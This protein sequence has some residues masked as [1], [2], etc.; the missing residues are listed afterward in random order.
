[1]LPDILTSVPAGRAASDRCPCASDSDVCVNVDRREE[2]LRVGF[3]EEGRPMDEPSWLL[4][5]GA[6][7]QILIQGP[8]Q[9]LADQVRL[10][11]D[12]LHARTVIT[13]DR[14]P[15]VLLPTSLY[16][17]YLYLSAL[18]NYVVMISFTLAT[19]NL[20]PFPFLDGGLCFSS[21]LEWAFPDKADPTGDGSQ[22]LLST[23]GDLDEEVEDGLGGDRPT[24][25]WRNRVEIGV[26]WGTG[27]LGVWV[28]GG[29]VLRLALNGYG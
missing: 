29:I 2:V 25:R 22:S 24:A 4:W 23:S 9:D 1:M 28:L 3:V 10:P 14:R 7:Q 26:A 17:A 11:T 8:P 15:P 13:S 5:Q 27:G 6:R 18:K 19:L 12:S 16:P 20:L 21:F